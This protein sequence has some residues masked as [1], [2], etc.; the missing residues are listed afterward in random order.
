MAE[1]ARAMPPGGVPPQPP[2]A[3]KQG[4]D[5]REIFITPFEVTGETRVFVKP[6]LTRIGSGES[7][8]EYIR[9]HNETKETIWVWLPNGHNYL[10]MEEDE[11]LQTIPIPPGENSKPLET[12]PDAE[13]KRGHYPYHVY[14]KQ[15]HNG[16]EGHSEPVI[17][18]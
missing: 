8:L 3:D 13:I 5:P 2:Q 7:K 17:V 1:P 12:R 14:C 11:A 10:K 6:Y 9:F 18:T 4:E 15:I 16:A